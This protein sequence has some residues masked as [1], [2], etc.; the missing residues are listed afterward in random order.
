MPQGV[1]RGSTR[2]RTVI[3]SPRR[4]YSSRLRRGSSDLDSQ[5]TTNAAVELAIA[6]PIIHGRHWYGTK[7]GHCLTHPAV[8]MLS[9]CQVITVT[10]MATTVA[11]ITAKKRSDNFW[12]NNPTIQARTIVQ[13]QI[14]LKS[15]IVDLPVF[16]HHG[17]SC[18]PK[19]PKHVNS[20]LGKFGLESLCKILSI[21]NSKP[22]S[23]SI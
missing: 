8:T 5:Y 9:H 12:A 11:A 16:V 17:H 1:A 2:V 18:I 14:W 13:T 19:T 3:T 10:G 20:L 7:A 6:V 21:S 4:C 22:A 15:M 23:Y